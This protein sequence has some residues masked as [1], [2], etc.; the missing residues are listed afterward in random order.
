MISIAGTLP[1]DDTRD[2]FLT[3]LG[4]RVRLMRSRRGVTRKVLAREAGIS[5]RHLANLETGTGN[6][7]VLLLRQLAQALNCSMAE[8]VGQD[9]IASP[10]LILIRQMLR[11]RDEATLQRVRMALADLLGA[12]RT[13]PNR[14]WRIALIGLRGAGKS[15]L[16]RMLAADLAV[17]F[18]ELNRVVE[19]L[20]GC[21]VHE[22]HSLYGSAAYRRY[23]HRALEETLSEFP[24]AVIA[25]GGGLVSEA[26]TFD[27]LLAHCF[28]V[29]LRASPEEHMQRVVAQ[30]DLRPMEGNLEAMDD[31]KRIL[32]GR[33]G[34]YAKAD[35][36]VETGD[37]SLEN[38]Y[39]DL[40]SGLQQTLARKD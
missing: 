9:G 30:G 14:S 39:F 6:P 26:P 31:L 11:G 25:T 36:T 4:E 3:V 35:L 37:K 40:R 12:S 8:L 2:P 18:V 34:L 1:D 33:E 38:A 21:E 32:A 15:T 23:E 5:E 7:S 20:A 22:I 17:P 29:W 19:R 16:G 10:E 24:K 28:T 27:L 13:D